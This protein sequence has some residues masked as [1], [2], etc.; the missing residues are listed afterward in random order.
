MNNLERTITVDQVSG[1][2]GPSLYIDNMRVAGSKPWGGGSV[3]AEWQTTPRPVLAALGGAPTRGALSALDPSE[4][5]VVE[6]RDGVVFIA[7]RILSATP[8]ERFYPRNKRWNVQRVDVIESLAQLVTNAKQVR[9]AI[10][11]DIH[12]EAALWHEQRRAA[13]W[14]LA[15]D[16]LLAA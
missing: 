1:V 6:V 14:A 15:L 10:T 16:I 12:K 8:G 9:H 3:L 7:G 13:E 4:T 11:A 5:I 2:E